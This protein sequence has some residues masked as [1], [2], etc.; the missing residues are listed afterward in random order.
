M[1][2]MIADVVKDDFMI[3]VPMSMARS[4]FARMTVENSGDDFF[5]MQVSIEMGEREEKRRRAAKEVSDRLEAQRAAA[6][7]AKPFSE[8]ATM[9][10]CLVEFNRYRRLYNFTWHHEYDL[11]SIGGIA[12][13]AYDGTY[14][15]TSRNKNAYEC[16]KVVEY[17]IKENLFGEP[18]VG[19]LFEYE[20]E[21]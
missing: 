14:V 11:T 15:G 9:E 13:C 20:D 10:E 5:R 12:V 2:T 4:I 19:P 6:E 7:A 3:N 1:T 8:R 21:E 17:G 16:L 18:F